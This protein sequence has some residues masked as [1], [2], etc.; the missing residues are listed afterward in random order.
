MKL[1]LIYPGRRGGGSLYSLE[2]AKKLKERV[3]L[4]AVVSRQA[5]NLE[6]WKKTNIKLIELATYTNISGLIYSTLDIKKFIKL[7]RELINFN[8]DIIYY[9]MLHL[10]TPLINLLV[11]GKPK[12]ITVHDPRPRKGE[13]NPLHLSQPFA[14]KQGQRFIVL[15]KAFVDVL[16]VKGIERE[17]IDVIPHGEFS[18]Y[19]KIAPEVFEKKKKKT[20]LFFGRID[21]YKGLDVLLKSFPIIKKSINELRLLIVGKGN[22][23]PY[24]ELLK[25]LDDVEIVNRW[26]DD[27]EV[28]FY[29][30]QASLLAVPYI[31]ASQS[32]VIPIAYMFKV[33]VI[34]SRVGGIPEQLDDGETGLLVETG[35]VNEL[36]EACIKLLKDPSLSKVFAENGYRKANKEWNWE[37]VADMVYN[38]CKKTV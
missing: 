30:N 17:K 2:I 8:P 24:E 19:K 38:S 27:A 9:P 33:P 29:F 22:M 16:S 4:L 10:W 25:N 32:G 37:R 28:S 34:A 26:I 12:L 23:S 21:K 13:F 1:A 7:R 36:A 3:D 14:L 6:E 15:S 11:P 18:Y 20:I 35:N 31:D 5:E